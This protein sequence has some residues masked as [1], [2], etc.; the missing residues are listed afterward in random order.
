VL[1]IRSREYDGAIRPEEKFR[2]IR[3][4][5]RAPERQSS[6]LTERSGDRASAEQQGQNPEQPSDRAIRYL[7][8]VPVPLL[9][10]P[11]TVLLGQR[12]RNSPLM[13]TGHVDLD[14]LDHWVRVGSGRRRVNPL[15]R[16][17]MAS[18]GPTG[19]CVPNGEPLRPRIWGGVVAFEDARQTG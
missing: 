13:L 16:P 3:R 9:R 1:D 5:T 7:V 14:E 11:I 4:Q 8:T 17:S 10:V 19:L 15:P 2:T 6:G 12:G 18:A